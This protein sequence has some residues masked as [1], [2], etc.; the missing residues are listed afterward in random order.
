VEALKEIG[1]A[2]AMQTLMTL[3]KD[4]DPEVRRMAAEALGRKRP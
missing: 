3:L 2:D 1:G 4:S